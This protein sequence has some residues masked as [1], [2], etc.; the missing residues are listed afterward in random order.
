MKPSHDDFYRQLR[1]RVKAWSRT[2][3][4]RENKWAS[5]VLVVPDV[6]HLLCKLMLR[7][8]VPP[9]Y[10][11]KLGV[12]IVYF[13]LPLDFIPEAIVGPLGYLDDLALSAWALNDLVNHTC[14][15]IVT[16]EWAGEG[17]ILEIIRHI[18]DVADEMVGPS[19]WA[20]LV[21]WWKS[22]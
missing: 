15:D 12:L 7:K 5:L 22:R 20:R 2:P 17:D 6:F 3:Q 13:V 10:K 9:R 8:D 14:T 16:E 11:A 1:D 19:M 18:L 21:Q 4:G